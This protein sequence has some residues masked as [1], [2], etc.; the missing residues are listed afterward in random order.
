MGN[1]CG[2]DTFD[3][4]ADKLEESNCFQR[5]SLIQQNKDFHKAQRQKSPDRDGLY[6]P[7]P[8]KYGHQT[9]RSNK[10]IDQAYNSPRYYKDGTMGST[11]INPASSE[12]SNGYNKQSSQGNYVPGRR[13]G[14]GVR[15]S[16]R[17]RLMSPP[18]TGRSTF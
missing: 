16:D 9:D 3:N 11:G 13:T 1:H 8:D 7:R 5:K 12:R 2:C 6:T 14:G 10:Q 18:L 15:E 17:N 4:K